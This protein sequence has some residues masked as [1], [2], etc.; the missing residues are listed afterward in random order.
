MT[1]KKCVLIHKLEDYANFTLSTCD[2][3]MMSLHFP[4][5]RKLHNCCLCII[6][7]VPHVCIYTNV[8][9]LRLVVYSNTAA[10][11]PP[12]TSP[13]GH[14]IHITLSICMYRPC[15]WSNIYIQ[16]Q[17]AITI[18]IGRGE[19][20]WM[21][22]MTNMCRIPSPLKMAGRHVCVCALHV[23]RGCTECL[24]YSVYWSMNKW[25]RWYLWSKV[26]KDAPISLWMLF[27]QQGIRGMLI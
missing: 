26:S 2:V 5:G 27:G 15:N 21:V 13:T 19:E 22:H 20:A 4:F 23:Q 18:I 17:C 1:L 9:M 25:T 7:P 12:F 11:L 8:Y 6:A 24:L 10:L 3:M 14:N 16:H